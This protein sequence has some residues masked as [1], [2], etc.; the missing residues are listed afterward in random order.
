MNVRLTFLATLVLTAGCGSKEADDTGTP[1][2]GNDASQLA[3]YIYVDQ[4]ATG[5]LSCFTPGSD[6]WPTQDVDSAL[7]ATYPA[8]GVVLDFQEDDP[9]EDATFTLWLSDDPRQT[10]DATAVS[11]EDGIVETDLISCKPMTY[12]TETDPDLEETKDTYEAHTVVGVPSGDTLSAEYTSVSDATYKLIPSLLGVTP[13]SDK[14]IIAGTAFDCNEE[15]IEGAQV[16]VRDDDGNIPETLIVKYFV[17]E[18]PNRYQEWTS[19]D[20]LWVA[21]QIPEGHY[22]VE[23]WGLVNGELALL[24]KTELS[25]FTDSINISNIYSGI[26]TGVKYPDS[27][28]V[29]GGE[30]TGDVGG[31]DTGN[32]GTDTGGAKTGK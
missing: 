19:T 12:K 5:D 25:I 3:D 24:G 21:L 10:P 15:K 16:V 14:G 23:M 18:W 8:A 13:D 28:L 9:I 1:D 4:E 2:T 20:G 29:G 22:F 27:C 31:K 7:V 26:P 17:D 32:G 6:E 30:D 11:D